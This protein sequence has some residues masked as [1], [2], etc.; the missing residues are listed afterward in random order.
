LL[1]LPSTRELYVNVADRDA[2]MTGLLRDGVVRSAEYQLRRRDGGIITVVENARLVRDE[3]GQVIGHEG[4][5]S[6]ISVRKQAEI[7]LFEEKEKAQVTLESI[8][9]AVITADAD[10]RVEYLNPVAEQLTGWE[11]AEAVGRPVGEVIQLVGETSRLPF[12]NPIVRCLREGRMVEM[13][14]QSL[15]INRRG[16]EIAIQDSAA[17]IRDRGGRL[18][19]VV[20]VFHDVSQERRLQR[21][22]AYQASHDALTGLINRREFESRLNEA[23]LAARS[24]DGVSHVLLYLDLDQFKVVND[25]CGHQAGDRLLKQLTSVVQTRI[26]TTD[27]LARLGGDEFGVLLQDCT[28]ETAQR[29]AENLRQAIR[30]F[31]FVW[32]DRVMNVG[33]SIGLAEITAQSESLAAVMSAADVACYS[34]KDSGRNRVQTYRQGR[35]PERH[36]EMQWVSRINRACEEDR[37]LLVCQPIVPIRTGVEK[38]RH[39]ELLLRMKDE[40]GVLVQPSEFIPAAER[41][42]LM[43]ALDRWVVR[44]ACTRHVHR[45]S[46]AQRAPFTLAIN[47]SATSL[48]DEQ[49]LDFVLAEMAA[50]DAGPGALCFEM[51]EAAAMSS[52]ANAKR[53]VRVLRERGCRFSLDDFGSGLSSFIFLKNLPVDFLKIDGQFMHN[54]AHDRIDRGL[55]EAIA[56]IGQTMG[57]RTIAERVDSA[58]VLDRLADIGIQYAQGHYIAAPQTVDNL[59]TLIAHEPGVVRRTA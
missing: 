16:I 47:I 13:V 57:I 31:R 9:D 4:T 7:Q 23:L 36:R 49:F 53:F 29:I 20:M 11:P 22:L 21:A 46:D 5:I 56:Q 52:L 50:A 28:L 41:F 1:A 8:G 45:R 43:P 2:V 40:N 32:Q 51:T 27:T 35:A 38:L 10:G 55:V 59:E 30:D 17:P 12:E 34:A 33:V 18:V 37:L 14:E 6:D 58:E 39:F 3:H 26:R 42:N 25:T 48:N 15:L 19:G 24:R 44:Q 54:V